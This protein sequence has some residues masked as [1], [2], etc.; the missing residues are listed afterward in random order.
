M[1]W[2]ILQRIA[3]WVQS[4]H[5]IFIK[6]FSL[7]IRLYANMQ[8]GHIMLMTII[9]L[10]Y[11][12]ERIHFNVRVAPAVTTPFSKSMVRR[13]HFDFTSTDARANKAACESTKMV[14]WRLSLHSSILLCSN[15]WHA[16]FMAYKSCKFYF[17]SLQNFNE[18]HTK[19]DH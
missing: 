18:Y 6:P 10:I 9:G 12:W 2:Y 1:V 8:A 11:I 13:T 4:I 14:I 5:G 7:L 17:T 19:Q 3:N 15:H 16:F